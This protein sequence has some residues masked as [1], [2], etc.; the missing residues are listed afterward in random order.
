MSFRTNRLACLTTHALDSDRTTQI[1]C[2]GQK[3]KVTGI[4]QASVLTL[5]FFA[6]FSVLTASAVSE[7][8]S[9]PPSIQQA[10]TPPEREAFRQ[11]LLRELE[12]YAKTHSTWN[13]PRTDGQFLRILVESCKIK[14]A[15]EIGSSNGYSTIWIGMGLERSGGKLITLEIDHGRAEM[16]KENVK[17][18][19]L[20]KVITGMEGDALKVIPTLKGPFD[21]VF[22]D[23]WK[24][25][26]KKHLDTVMPRMP[27]GVVIAAHNAIRMASSMRDYL[28][29]V[30]TDPRFDTVFLS[31]T[32]RDGF[33]ITYKKAEQSSPGRQR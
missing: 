25:D 10:K 21:F 18:A 29:A 1:N 2:G 19:G 9:S 22:I 26:Y 11:E 12:E 15:L 7:E 27:V 20:E 14:R 32:M 28:D 31:T 8:G 30:K 33:A 23:A 5:I 17:K 3:L 13:V 24:P 4:L 6:A 16:C